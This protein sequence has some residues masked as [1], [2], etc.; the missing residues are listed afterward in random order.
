MGRAPE[1][2][3]PA[4]KLAAPPAVVAGFLLLP[5]ALGSLALTVALSITLGQLLLGVGAV[6]G[7]RGGWRRVHLV[8]LGTALVAA[9]GLTALVQGQQAV[10]AQARERAEALAAR[11]AEQGICPPAP[12][13]FQCTQGACSTTW[14]HLGS[15]YRI[16]Y[17]RLAQG[18]RFGLEVRHGFGVSE[19]Y[20]GGVSGGVRGD[21]TGP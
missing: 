11:C 14:R 6:L 8:Q 1:G 2:A 15:G 9:A 4:W 19:R 7:G 13:G 17:R 18:S 10:S 21:R 5:P 3:T 16:D 12:V 20:T